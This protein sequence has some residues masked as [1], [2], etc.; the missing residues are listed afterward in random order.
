MEDE[1][2]ELVSIVYPDIAFDFS[3]GSIKPDIGKRLP[4][5]EF[6]SWFFKRDDNVTRAM[7]GESIDRVC[8]TAIVYDFE[9]NGIVFQ[10]ELELGSISV[11]TNQRTP[12]NN[13]VL[14]KDKQLL[15]KHCTLFRCSI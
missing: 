2:E 10:D 8:G 1:E 7:R 12:F 6:E 15:R 14:L 3:I 4:R 5:Q 13:E 11:Y 9:A